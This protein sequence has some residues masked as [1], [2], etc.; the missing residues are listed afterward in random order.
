MKRRSSRGDAGEV[1]DAV[2]RGTRVGRGARLAVATLAAAIAAACAPVQEGPDQCSDRNIDLLAVSDAK[3]INLPQAEGGLTAAQRAEID[4]AVLLFRTIIHE[5]NGAPRIENGVPVVRETPIAGCAVAVTRDAQIAYLQGYGFA[6]IDAGRD[7]TVATP[8]AVGSISKTLTALGALALTQ[9][10]VQPLQL[11][12][13]ALGQMGLVPGVDVPWKDFTLRQLLAHRA[14]FKSANDMDWDPLAFD[15][16]PGIAAAFPMIA[17]P[18]LQPLLVFQG[19]KT[20][21][22]NQPGSVGGSV[23]YS[24]PGYSVLGTLLD[25]RSR[26]ADVPVHQRGYESFLWHTV[27]RGTIATGPSMTSMCLATDF[28]KDDIKNLAQGYSADGDDLGFGDSATEGWGW[29]GPAGGWTLTI[30]DLARLMLVLQSSAVV[31][32][33]TIEGEMRSS[34][35]VFGSGRMGLGLELSASGAESWFGKGGA[36]L[37]YT[38]DFKV[39]PRSDGPDWGVAFMCNQSRAGFGLTNAIHDVLAGNGTGGIPGGVAGTAPPTA[40][41]TTIALVKRYETDVRNV[42]SRY[43]RGN[44]SGESAWVTARAD[45][46]RSSAGRSF[47][48]AVERGDLVGAARLVPS[49]LPTLAPR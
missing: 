15:D 18:S 8:S 43:L 22:S 48:Q 44:V 39:W 6:D 10:L 9:R 28:R 21:Q 42:A 35:G 11:D 13:S 4:S 38:A 26:A 30:G 34:H 45:L 29:E 46:Q 40:D 25:Q 33:A 17:H 49:V 32:K 41:P 24:N 23:V 16:G 12:A 31:P 37:G 3:Y 2:D 7:F 1:R 19:Y 27:G 5:P 36:I 20:Q 47:V 14:G